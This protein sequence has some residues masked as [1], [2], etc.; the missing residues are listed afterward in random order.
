MERLQAQHPDEG[1]H[2]VVGEHSAAA[3]LAGARVQGDLGTDLV[4]GFGR[5]L[6]RGHQVDR[7]AGGGVVPW[8]DRSVRH[9][10]RGDVR[11][12]HGGDRAD[13]GLVAGDHGNES[14]HLVGGQVHRGG[15]VDELAPDEGEPHLGGAVELPV[16][17][18]DGEGRR[19]QAHGQIIAGDP[20]RHG[21]L[22]RGHLVLDTEVALAVPEV[23]EHGPHGV[24]DLGDVLAQEPG[25]ADPLHITTGIRGLRV[26]ALRPTC[27]VGRI[28]E[29]RLR[30]SLP[31]EQGDHDCRAATAECL[32]AAEPSGPRAAGARRRPGTPRSKGC[33]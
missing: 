10:H 5:R 31:T 29:V 8:L 12:Q 1:L 19:D 15:V 22:H 2:G 24:V 21:G 9:D 18:P 16:R 7:V 3:A 30:V 28:H 25:R 20:A 17:H 14:G 4:V 23:A 32:A 33:R 26:G 6:K 13:R 27:T 11:L